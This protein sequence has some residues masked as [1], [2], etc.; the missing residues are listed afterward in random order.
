MNKDYEKD[1][2]K[3]NKKNKDDKSK[4]ILKNKEEVDEFKEL[5]KSKLILYNQK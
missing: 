1:S 5:Q 4:E 2:K 3:Y